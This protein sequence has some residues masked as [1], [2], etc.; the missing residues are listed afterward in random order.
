LQ[1]ASSARQT[2]LRCSGSE[3]GCSKVFRKTPLVW[4]AIFRLKLILLPRQARDKHTRENS[5]K[6]AFFLEGSSNVCINAAVRKTPSL[7]CHFVQKMINLVLPRQARDKHTGKTQKE[8]AFFAG[9][10]GVAPGRHRRARRRAQLRC[11]EKRISFA[12]TPF[13]ILKMQHHFTKTGSGQ[14]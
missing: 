5:N 8:A 4:D 12:T 11:G 13:L 3:S 1:A 14:T 2:K 7:R 10:A 6:E 9:A